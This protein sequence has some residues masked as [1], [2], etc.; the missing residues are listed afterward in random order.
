MEGRP[1]LLSYAAYGTE[2][3][4]WLIVQ[5]NNISDYEEDLA[6]GKQIKIPII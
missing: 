3:L 6:A 2:L 4:W 5:A 1:D